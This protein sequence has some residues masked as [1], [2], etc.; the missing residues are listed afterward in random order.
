MRRPR[1][2]AELSRV[3]LSVTCITGGAGL[4]PTSSNQNAS[5]AVQVTEVPLHGN[6]C[7]LVVP[8]DVTRRSTTPGA[9]AGVVNVRLVPLADIDP[10]V[11]GAPPSHDTVESAPNPLPETVTTVPPLPGPWVGVTSLMTGV[12]AAA[13]APAPP[14]TRADSVASAPTQHPRARIMAGSIPGLVPIR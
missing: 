3:G 11:I 6:V 1:R 7:S 10:G 12:P 9:C 4:P 14:T 2:N 8:P 13:A 5:V